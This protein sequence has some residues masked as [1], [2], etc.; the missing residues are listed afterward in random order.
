MR[1]ALAIRRMAFC[2]V[3]HLDSA[4]A[5]IDRERVK[6]ALKEMLLEAAKATPRGGM[7]RL[8]ANWDSEARKLDFMLDATPGDTLLDIRE[9][10]VPDAA[11][12]GLT[13]S[14]VL[15]RAHGGSFDISSPGDSRIRMAF[16]VLSGRQRVLNEELE[17]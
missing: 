3:P 16:H 4:L 14:S 5:L 8:R 13:F 17:D 2:V 15:A 9:A 1:S 10:E 11:S 6:R 12:I 7:I